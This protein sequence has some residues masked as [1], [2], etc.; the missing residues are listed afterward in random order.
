[1]K[2]SEIYNFTIEADYPVR[3]DKL[4]AS[5]FPEYS[6]TTI[7]KWINNNHILINGKPCL[8]K[9]IIKK[10]SNVQVTAHFESELNLIPEDIPLDI[11]DETDDYIVINK[12]SGI[13]TH[14]APGNYQGTLQNAI[15]FKY[16]E[17]SK[18]PRTGIIHRLDKDTSGIIVIARTSLYHNYL[19]EQL[20]D[21]KFTK[22]YHAL[23]SGVVDQKININEKIG[24]HPIN[25]KKMSI[26][27]KGKD[28]QSIISPMMNY[29]RASHLQIQ[30]ITGR[31]HQ[32]RVHLSH[33][34]HPIIGDKLYGFKKNIFM[35]NDKI[36]NT[37]CSKFN[38]YLHAYSLSFYD[39]K[40]RLKKTYV[41]EYPP[42][43]K[44]LK[45]VLENENN[46]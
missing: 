45:R 39:M 4:L 18:V 11:I 32:I 37:L 17:L 16:P 44:N 5:H 34:A 10:A 42:E 31:T 30:I 13:V 2:E 15:Y 21:K 40:S 41:A 24:R 8:Q 19:T 12:P 46:H 43:Y 33:I 22:I 25:R 35:K 14:V 9:D 27:N 26:S 28:A 20:H 38:Q 23:V 36:M 3:L 1:M 29:Q 7:Q 6:R